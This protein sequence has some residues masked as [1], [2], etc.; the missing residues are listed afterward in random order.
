[1]RKAI[2][3]T[4][5][6]SAGV[7]FP[8]TPLYAAVTQK[9]SF[10]VTRAAHPLPLDPKLAD[11]GWL[12]GR[13]PDSGAWIDVT[14]RSPATEPTDAYFLYD[15]R[16]LYVAFK[17]TQNP[18]TIVA[19]QTTNDV[20]F[21]VD[22]FVGIGIDT[23]GAGS[24]AYYFET[25]P[26]GVRYEQALENVRYRP[27][28]E[29]AATIGPDGWSAVL[30]IPLSV[31]K[32]RG[33]KDQTWRIQFVRQLAAKG[34][35]CVWAYDGLMQDAGSGNW[36]TFADTR[37]WAAAT[38]ISTGGAGRKP[39]GRVDVFGLASVGQD[40]NLFQQ[41]D[42][43]FLPMQVRNVG[44]D[45][46]YPI[47]PTMSFVGTI[48]PDFSNVEIDQETIAP[49]EFRRQ[50]VE[51]RPFFAQGANYINANSGPRSPTSA[52]STVPNY[53]FYS[54]D[55]GPFDRGAKVEGTFGDQSLGVLSFRGF[56]Q[57]TGDT[58]DDQAYGYEHAL[59]DGTFLYWSDG[60]FGHHS[61]SGNDTTIEAGMEGR[62][63]KSGFVWFA[64][65]AFENGDWI[66]PGHADLGDV[67]VDVHKPNYEVNAGYFDVSPFY[68]PIDGFTTN[69]DI[70]G[71]QGFFNFDG[72]TTGIK[73]WALFIGGD[74]FLDNSGAVHQADTQ[75]FF[76]AT[77]KNGFS[78]NGAGAAIGQ[79][80]SYGV[81]AGPDCSGPIVSQTSFSGYP[82]YLD[83]ITQQFNLS[84]IP[85]GY[86]DGTPRPIDVSYSWGPFGGNETHLFDISTARP[87]GRRMTLGLEYSGTYERPLA[88]PGALDSQW[89]RR[90][91]VGYNLGPESTL[92]ISFRNIN[93]LGGFSTQPGTNVA[94]GFHARF[95]GGNELYVNYGSPA[96]N[97]TLNRT[98]M[99]YVFHVGADE[100]T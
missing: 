66:L 95:R 42:G 91:S 57:T 94:I 85:I 24:Q 10:P 34:E 64:D 93:G 39:Q 47:T 12:A 78:I 74:R 26:R 97:T 98:I 68:D 22:D 16:F 21:G 87:V 45:L 46:S 27:R 59:Q 3:L 51:Y 33:G 73:N 41:A 2:G 56:D 82:C 17:A 52:I 75:I 61:I 19:T 88:G 23:S 35:H 1:M 4:L 38:G 18:Q 31:L 79:L 72:S 49:Q 76:N 81:P 32:V 48:A 37:W 44:L 65:Y 90:V 54:P 13:V 15:D 100:G 99:K 6:L 28:W 80:R 55:I 30:V 67:F 77:F 96:A 89:L 83:G 50:L 5:A 25:T 20:G 84:T 71:P 63:L 9:F 11:P 29:S 58:F 70:H 40:R 36:P 14:T 62:N 43:L 7:A 69:S 86:G 53:V 8:A 92:T 60:V